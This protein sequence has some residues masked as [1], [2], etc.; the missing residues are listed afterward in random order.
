MAKTF[1]GPTPSADICR[2]LESDYMCYVVKDGAEYLIAEAEDVDGFYGWRTP[3]DGPD[4]DAHAPAFFGWQW[5]DDYTEVAEAIAN[6]LS[7]A[8][9]LPEGPTQ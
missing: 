9:H 8:A 5:D 7:P 2:A 1:T 4:A 3:L 6:W